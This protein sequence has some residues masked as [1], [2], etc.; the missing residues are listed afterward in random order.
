[1]SEPWISDSI[2]LGPQLPVMLPCILVKF[3][4]HYY[5]HQKWSCSIYISYCATNVSPLCA[6]WRAPNEL[7]LCHL[8]SISF[9]NG[10]T[11]FSMLFILELTCTANHLENKEHSDSLPIS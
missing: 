10:L 2:I 5:A 8:S 6:V 7:A 4:K 9:N 11:H 1:M 3:A